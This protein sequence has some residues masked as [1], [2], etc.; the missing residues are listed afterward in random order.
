[1][2][3]AKT[4][5]FIL[6][7]LLF[8]QCSNTTT[9]KNLLHTPENWRSEIIEFPLEFAPSLQY[10]GIEYVKFAPGWGKENAVDYFS[11]TFLWDIDKD[12]LLSTKK[13][14]S[15]MESY[16][17]GLMSS[18]SRTDQNTTS[19]IPKTKAFFEKIKDSVY[20]GKILTYDSFI[21]KKELHLN[22]VVNYSFCKT[23]NKHFVLFTISP[24]DPEHQIWKKMKTI[25]IDSDCK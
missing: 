24:K 21:T 13:L 5:P 25:R 6:I 3:I 18:I 14:E 23:Q 22:M 10:S 7:I 11:Y 20:I 19:Q 1:M 15:D 17:D 12:P 16:F 2:S 9:S 8:I 4:I